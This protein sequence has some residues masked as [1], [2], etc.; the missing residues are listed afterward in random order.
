[1]VL[2]C[3]I[4][5]KQMSSIE[6]FGSNLHLVCDFVPLSFPILSARNNFGWPF[7]FILLFFLLRH[8]F[9]FSLH[10]WEWFPSSSSSSLFR[11][12]TL[13][14]IRGPMVTDWEE[15]WDCVIWVSDFI[16][17]HIISLHFIVSHFCPTSS[18]FSHF[19]PFTYW[20]CQINGSWE[21]ESSLAFWRCF[22][23]VDFHTWFHL[24]FPFHLSSPFWSLLIHESAM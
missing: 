8:F 13:Q 5:H 18:V 12:S 14:S 17:F 3:S 2:K 4:E 6:T 24:S 21:L 16:S 9:I 19:S 22:V 20:S 7:V 11:F 10:F 15:S 23:V 1:M